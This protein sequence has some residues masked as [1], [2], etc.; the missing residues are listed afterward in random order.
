MSTIAPTYAE[1]LLR[2]PEFG[3]TPEPSVSAELALSAELLDPAAWGEMYSEGVLYDSAHNL[4]LSTMASTGAQGAFQGAAG[5]VSNV[6]GAGLS[7]GFN[8][9]T[10]EGKGH[11]RDWYMKTVYGQRFLRLRSVTIP[12]A[13]LTI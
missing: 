6:S 3:N 9:P 1:F 4:L 5:P 11:S 10:V 7:V 12:A 2:F 13:E 8:T